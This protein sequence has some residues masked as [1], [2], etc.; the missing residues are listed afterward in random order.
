MVYSNMLLSGAPYKRR[1]DWSPSGGIWTHNL[2]I[3]N[4]APYQ[5][6]QHPDMRLSPRK[7]PILTGHGNLDRPTPE[8]NR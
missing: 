7:Q 4:Q 6:E 8:S 5:V 1:E 2:L 3:P